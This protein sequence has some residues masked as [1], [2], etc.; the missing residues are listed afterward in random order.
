MIPAAGP[1]AESV[2]VSVGVPRT[3]FNA[4]AAAFPSDPDT[5]MAWQLERGSSFDICRRTMGGVPTVWPAPAL[6]I[7]PPNGSAPTTQRMNGEDSLS[8]EPGGQSTKDANL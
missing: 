5:N 6:L 7:R 2:T 4:S 8:N 3:L 1:S